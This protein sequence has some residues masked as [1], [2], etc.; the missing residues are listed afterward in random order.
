M[1]LKE[2][3]S[4]LVSVIER[5]NQC[6]AETQTNSAR[7]NP[8]QN[9]DEILSRLTDELKEKKQSLRLLLRRYDQQMLSLMVK[10][11]IKDDEM[12]GWWQNRY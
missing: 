6:I 3:I 2:Q 5:Q 12:M 1:E 11:G 4:D 9:I 10:G 7:T 8:P